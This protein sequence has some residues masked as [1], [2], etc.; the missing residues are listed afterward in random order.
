MKKCKR[1]QKGFIM[2]KYNGKTITKLQ[3]ADMPT[4]AIA[5]FYSH[6]DMTLWTDE[7]GKV[8]EF[9][10]DNPCKGNLMYEY[11]SLDS[12]VADFENL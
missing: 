10:N 8:Y 12:F 5:E 3:C 1:L 6:A 11:E 2:R 9:C 4:E 7:D